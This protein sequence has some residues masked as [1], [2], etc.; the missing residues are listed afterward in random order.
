MV[1]SGKFP[2][3]NV[4]GLARVFLGGGGDLG[5]PCPDPEGNCLDGD[6]TR[7][8]GTLEEAPRLRFGGGEV[9]G[10]GPEGDFGDGDSGRTSWGFFDDVATDDDEVPLRVNGKGEES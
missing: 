6:G 3:L 4:V 1:G 5:L 7:R 9:S 10:P 8:V 2:G